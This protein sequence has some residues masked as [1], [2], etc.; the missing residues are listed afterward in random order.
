MKGVCAYLVRCAKCHSTGSPFQQ[1][2]TPE[3]SA[4][5]DGRSISVMFPTVLYMVDGLATETLK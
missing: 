2:K 4:I 5:N 1:M 3:R